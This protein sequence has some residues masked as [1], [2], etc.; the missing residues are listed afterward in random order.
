MV[1]DV[2]FQVGPVLPSPD[3]QLSLPTHSLGG[4]AD[5]NGQYFP[6][7][8]RRGFRF[9]QT[10]ARRDAPPDP[11]KR[12]ANLPGDVADD[13]AHLYLV[14]A[15]C[16]SGW[17]GTAAQ[18]NPSDLFHA[19]DGGVEPMQDPPVTSRVGEARFDQTQESPQT[20]HCILETV[21]EPGDVFADLSE[22]TGFLHLVLQLFQP[23]AKFSM[24]Q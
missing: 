9:R 21:G 6:K 13:A 22:R 19:V 1:A 17:L 5:Q 24:A 7:H 10:I 8:E 16:G 4:V 2:D 23:Q 18:S 20:V 11:W 15:D 3:L 12:Q 14:H